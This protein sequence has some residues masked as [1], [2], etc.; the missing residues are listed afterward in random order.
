VRVERKIIIENK[1]DGD[2]I[3]MYGK[4]VNGRI[5]FIGGRGKAKYWREMLR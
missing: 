4:T 3:K 1:I 5:K 2:K